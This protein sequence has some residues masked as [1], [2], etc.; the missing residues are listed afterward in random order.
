MRGGDL[1]KEA[2]RRCGLTQVELAHRAHTTQSGIA[3]WESNKTCPSLEDVIRII[4]LC[5][6]DLELAI[7]P[8]DGSDMAQAERLLTL[9][10]EERL[11]WHESVTRQMSELRHGT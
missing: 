5:D 1:I 3:R 4:R 9:T 10:C 7:V 11:L 2:R 8:Y 6:L